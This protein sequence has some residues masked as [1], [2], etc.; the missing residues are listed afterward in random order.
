M[1]GLIGIS[2]LQTFTIDY[3]AQ[4]TGDLVDAVSLLWPAIAFCARRSD[5]SGQGI[6]SSLAYFVATSL[7]FNLSQ[8]GIDALSQR[9]SKLCIVIAAFLAL[10]GKLT[11]RRI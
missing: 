8:V 3:C 10:R 7:S 4:A 1:Y 5:V 6:Q 9:M 11:P 2:Q